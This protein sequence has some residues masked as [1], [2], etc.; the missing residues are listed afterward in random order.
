[1]E[2]RRRQACPCQRPDRAVC[3]VLRVF[4]LVLM[5]QVVSSQVASTQQQDI[6]VLLRFTESIDNW[7][8]YKQANSILGWDRQTPACA[9]SGIMCADDGSI[10]ILNLACNRCAVKAVGSLPPS[11]GQ[12]ARLE[13]LNLGNNA[14]FGALPSEWSA[15]GYWPRLSTL[16]LSANQLEG[17]LPGSWG[18][19]NAFPAMVQ[20]RLSDNDLQGTIPAQ[21]GIN[22]NSMS[23]LT[24][25]RLS[26]NRLEGTI[27]A[28]WGTPAA[29]QN[30]QTLSLDS[31]NLSGTTFPELWTSESSLLNLQELNLAGN[32]FTAPLPPLWGSPTAQGLATLRSLSV[33][34]NP[35][36]GSLP[37]E[38]GVPGA[39]PNL[40]AL[41]VTSANLQGFL[42]PNWGS[43]GSFPLL[44]TMSISKNN[45]GGPVPQSWQD[46]PSLRRLYINPG[47]DNL[48]GSIPA[49][50]AFTVCETEDVSIPS[51]CIGNQILLPECS[52]E[53]INEFNAYVA[54]LNLTTTEDDVSSGGTTASDSSSSSSS[55]VGAIVGGV[56]GG[57]VAVALL[58]L[59]VFVV[60]K[61]KRRMKLSKLSNQS[62]MN[63]RSSTINALSAPLP[64]GTSDELERGMSPV[65]GR[66]SK[67]SPMYDDDFFE[68][69]SD[70]E[71]TPDEIT[72]LKRPDGSDWLLGSGG[73]GKVYK[74]TRHN[75]STVAVKIIP[76]TGDQRAAA[77][78]E[79]R[80]EIAILRAC[81]DVN[82][83]QFIGAYLGT[84]ET[85]LVT[86]YLE[87]GDLMLNIKARRVTWWRR[88]K[89]VAIDIAKGLVF[90]HSRRIMH[91]DLK[92]SNIL[93]AR[94]G[95]A[96]I[97]D[98]GMAR[99]M[100]QDYVTGII[101]TLAWSAPE[102]LFNARCSTAVDIYSF[103]IILWEIATGEIPERGRLRD[104]EVPT[105]C[106]I[107]LRK[108]ILECLD[109][110]PSIRPTAI[111]MVERLQLVPGNP[112]EV[113]L[114]T[115]EN[116]AT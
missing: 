112:A 62:E 87:A 94:D 46:F 3:E 9:W 89:K 76:A 54:S 95:T 82:I 4:M 29:F 107:E 111:Q 33:G 8:E 65:T 67:E 105:E 56:V 73:F 74:G 114:Q 79:T 91:A 116:G 24:I 104:L 32:N 1:M 113:G 31:N 61:R 90:L 84:E 6:A 13:T 36:Q 38:W 100:A 72:I 108:L 115:S 5:V 17:S 21:W 103:G 23:L 85:W 69:F 93:I 11:L 40:R 59:V 98:V 51:P 18:D 52:E 92:S 43:D 70:W 101:S 78:A 34:L 10:I 22:S 99:V 88:G 86:E 83:V 77:V 80:K 30:L 44:G 25:I 55:N 110:R 96:K 27:P 97:A 35:L 39:W 106:P 102:I 109:S 50:S 64:F 75:Y 66:T 68:T 19:A 16:D 12:L 47:N 2:H 63:K 71:V 53:A 45:L 49:D 60:L 26:N 7:E 20:L 81:R 41:N 14:F 57:V 37:P 58:G 28:A 42:P 48:C 15:N